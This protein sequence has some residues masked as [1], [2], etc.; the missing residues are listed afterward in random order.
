MRP[1][2]WFR[3]RASAVGEN[4]LERLQVFEI[5]AQA[6]VTYRRAGFTFTVDFS[7][8]EPHSPGL[9]K[10]GAN[11]TSNNP[12]DHSPRLWYAGQRVGKPLIRLP[13]SKLAAFIINIPRLSGKKPATTG[14]QVWFA[15][16]PPLPRRHKRKIAQVG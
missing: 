9:C 10:S 11:A 4:G 13:K 1:P 6:S 15:A 8:A 16:P 2:K 5:V 7:K 12:P 14:D 3:L